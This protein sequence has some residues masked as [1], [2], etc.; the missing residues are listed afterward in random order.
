MLDEPAH[1][2]LGAGQGFGLAEI[3]R[4]MSRAPGRPRPT[5]VDAVFVEG[6]APR[7]II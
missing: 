7:S 1:Q 4:A 3:A 5:V 6:T 2:R